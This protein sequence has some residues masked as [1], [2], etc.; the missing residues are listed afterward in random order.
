MSRPPHHSTAELWVKLVIALG[1]FGALLIF[2]W[3]HV[4]TKYTVPYW[5]FSLLV[6]ILGSMIGV[7]IIRGVRQQG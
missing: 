1:S 7:D 4:T 5:F 3:V 2:A 6:L